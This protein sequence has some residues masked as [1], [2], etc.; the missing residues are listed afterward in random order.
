MTTPA[1]TPLRSV[2]AAFTAGATSRDAL[3]RITGLPRDVVDA[4][5]DHLVRTG[6][7]EASTL[8]TGCADG[9]CGGC[10]LAHAGCSG[11][12][13]RFLRNRPLVALTVVAQQTMVVLPSVVAQPPVVTDSGRQP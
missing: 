10:V 12:Q 7:I 2:L 9:G 6:R 5:I 3:C 11:A 8:S 4:A 1:T 13:S